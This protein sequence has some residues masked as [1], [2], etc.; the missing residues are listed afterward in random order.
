MTK[1]KRI[2]FL[3]AIIFLLFFSETLFSLDLGINFRIGNLAFKNDRSASNT[4]F[5]GTNYFY[6]LSIF[7]TA[8]ISD[9]FSFESGFFNDTILKNISYTIF[10]YRQKFI[11]IGVGPFFGFF[12]STST[13]LK[14]GI[15]TS[16]RLELPGIVFLRFRSDST[17]GGRLIEIGDYIQERNNI[18]AGYYVKNA[19]CSLNLSSKKYIQKA[20]STTETVDSL[21]E[22]SFKTEVFQKNMP[23]TVDIAFAYQTLKK[24]FIT[25]TTTTKHTLD[26][27]ILKTKLKFFIEEFLTLYTD[28]ESSIY[29]FGEDELLG[30]SNPGPGGYLFRLNTGITVN[31]DKIVN[32]NKIF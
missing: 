7:T 11:T 29:T 6:G 19:I 12:N 20:N 16:I 9:N 3:L 26:S 32:L 18:S 2:I 21:T 30:I 10:N 15:S 24:E 5:T 8:S 25:S 28:L 14:S 23:Y 4:T 31:L 27:I 17:I 13:I 22:Y 1:D